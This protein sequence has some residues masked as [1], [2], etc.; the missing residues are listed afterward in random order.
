MFKTAPDSIFLLGQTRTP[1]LIWASSPTVESEP[2]TAASNT[3]ARRSTR[4][5]REITQAERCASSPINAPFQTIGRLR[6]ASAPIVTLSP[7]TVP[8]S[9]CTLAPIR[10]LSPITAGVSI[11]AVWSM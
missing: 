1:G 2:T 6:F 8:A 11:I 9:I 7:I 3:W 5:P 4:V 10:Q